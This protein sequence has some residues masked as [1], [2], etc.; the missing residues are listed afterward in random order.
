MPTTPT[1]RPR[2]RP[3]KLIPPN[4][5]SKPDLPPRAWA[6]I[7][8]E[9][10]SARILTLGQMQRELK[11]KKNIELTRESIRR[12]R[13]KPLYQRGVAWLLTKYLTEALN[14]EDI[15]TKK[16][17]RTKRNL[18][19]RII[20]RRARARLPKYIE[21]NWY[22]ATRS[23]HDGAIYTTPEA[24]TAHL[25]QADLVPDGLIAEIGAEMDAELERIRVSA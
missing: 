1:G 10:S 12:W 24:Y 9:I 14:E 3:K 18:A 15:A 16:K 4:D 8:L 17:E 22:G 7:E 20:K 5:G 13:A 6:A 23:M 11:Q 25:L 21:R 19:A 2:G